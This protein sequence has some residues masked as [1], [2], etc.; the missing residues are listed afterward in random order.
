MNNLLFQIVTLKRFRRY[1][2]S[3]N[4]MAEVPT[5][6]IMVNLVIKKYQYAIP[7]VKAFLNTAKELIH[8]IFDIWT[9]AERIVPRNPRILR[10]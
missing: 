3:V 9:S 7:Q 4:P 1:F 10:R 6:Q 5:R 8:L 2:K